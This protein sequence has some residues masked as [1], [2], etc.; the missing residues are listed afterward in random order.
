[1]SSSNR[2]FI[3]DP[4]TDRK[5]I[6]CAGFQGGTFVWAARPVSQAGETGVRLP[7]ATSW[8]YMTRIPFTW[9]EL[10]E[11]AIYDDNLTMALD[12]ET[13]V[14]LWATITR[15]RKERADRAF[16]QVAAVERAVIEKNKAL[17]MGSIAEE[18]GR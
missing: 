17:L 3:R 11:G 16:S 15:K 7:N 13:A 5:V 1:M 4:F 2:N 8:P 10:K 9:E 6:F 14:G 12:L 18:Q